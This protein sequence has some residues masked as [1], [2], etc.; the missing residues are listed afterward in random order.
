MQPKQDAEAKKNAACDDSN[1]ATILPVHVVIILLELLQNS[2]CTNDS[3]KHEKKDQREVDIHL[4]VV[5]IYHPVLFKN[6]CL[7]YKWYNDSDQ[8][9]DHIA[10]LQNSIELKKSKLFINVFGSV[11]IEE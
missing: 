4:K 7:K 5:K 1:L 10:H 9:I 3:A 8:M 2:D 11:D 6:V